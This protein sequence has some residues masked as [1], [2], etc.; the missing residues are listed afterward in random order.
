[1]TLPP[2]PPPPEATAHIPPKLRNNPKVPSPFTRINRIITSIVLSLDAIWNISLIPQLHVD[3]TTQV[4]KLLPREWTSVIEPAGVTIKR[5]ESV[6][7]CLQL[8]K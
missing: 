5:G 1:M 8:F 3:M 2:P 7:D 4:Y 6:K